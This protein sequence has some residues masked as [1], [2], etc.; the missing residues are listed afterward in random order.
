MPRRLVRLLV[1]RIAG[2]L[3]TPLVLVVTAVIGA[4]IGLLVAPR[5]SPDIALGVTAGLAL[6][7]AVAGL[8]LWTRLLRE[9]PGLR[10]TLEMTAQGVP[11]SAL[12]QRLIHPD[13]PQQGGPS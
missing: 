7:G 9:H 10:H 1:L 11:E 4:T 3:L 12:V 13:D 5:L 6:V 8:A 2:W